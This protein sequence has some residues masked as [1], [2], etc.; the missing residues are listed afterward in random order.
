MT[1]QSLRLVEIFGAHEDWLEIV[2]NED[3]AVDL[4]GYYL[5][6]RLNQ[7]M[8]WQFPLGIP[9]STV[10]QPGEFKLIWADEDNAQGWNHTNFKFNSGGEVIVLRSVD[11]FS[12]ADSVHFNVIPT[13]HSL[14]RSPDVTGPWQIF[15]PGSTTPEYCNV[16]TTS[17]EQIPDQVTDMSE[18]HFFPNPI[19]SG[20]FITINSPSELHDMNGRKIIDYQTSGVHLLNV[21]PGL[22]ILRQTKGSGLF[23]QGE[24]LIVTP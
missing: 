2:N 21:A 15:P 16:C 24:K 1:S 11:G 4:A 19:R 5:T 14:G 13:D 18:N 20:A 12:I 6:D 10:I 7:P 8:K 3:V 22:Y 9:D 23:G 17:I